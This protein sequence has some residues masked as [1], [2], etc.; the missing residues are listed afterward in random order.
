METWKGHHYVIPAS[1]TQKWDNHGQAQSDPRITS[2]AMEIQ[3]RCNHSYGTDW[4][5]ELL[6]D[7]ASMVWTDNPEED[8]CIAITIDEAEM[9]LK[10]MEGVCPI[11][12]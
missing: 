1:K 8:R 10:V 6:E 11:C 5:H 4:L 2:G 3:F 12:E 7:D 9:M